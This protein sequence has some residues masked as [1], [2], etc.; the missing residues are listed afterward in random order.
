MATKNIIPRNN[1]EG[2]IGTNSK[3]WAEGHFESLS[4]AG[5]SVTG[6]GATNL[7]GLTDVTISSVQNNQ[8]LKY[9]TSNSRWENADSAASLNSLPEAAI[10]VANDFIAFVDTDDNASKKESVSDLVASI[11]GSGLTATNGVLAVNTNS[12]NI[13]IQSNQLQFPNMSTGNSGLSGGQGGIVKVDL[14]NL[15]TTATVNVASDSFAFI[16]SD[17]SQDTF[18]ESI[19]DL[20]AAVAG[21]GLSAS[22]GVLSVSGINSDQISEGSSNLYFTNEKVDDRVNA[23]IIAGA[24]ISKTYNDSSNTLTLASDATLQEVISS[25][26]TSAIGASIVKV[27]VGLNSSN[28]ATVGYV[29]T[30]S[31]NN[32][33]SLDPHGSGIVIATGNSTRG[34]GKIKLNCEN[35][36]HGVTIQSPPHSAGATYTLTLP[37]NNGNAD[38]VLKTN[39]SGV[40][41]WVDQ[42]SGGG[43][44]STTLQN[45]VTSTSTLSGATS[46]THVWLLNGSTITVT[47]PSSGITNGTIYQI[48]N[49]NSTTATVSGTID[50]LSSKSLSQY[51]NLTLVATSAGSQWYI[52]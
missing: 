33:L 46:G 30:L 43:G 29:S 18:K 5:Q 11:K 7:N 42:A 3:K 23:L 28:Q 49:I 50:N 17:G 4:V 44:S 51:D 32:N 34:A 35:N 16:D 14:D 21:S 27:G 48:K 19:A 25:N 2:K 45:T 13:I 24:G 47:L 38:Q 41:S 52:L 26:P 36:S 10:S 1:N 40:L 39:G 31:D 37:I 22:S 9:N 6:G 12:N 15:P 8:V 20:I